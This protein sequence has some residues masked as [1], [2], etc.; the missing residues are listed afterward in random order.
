MRLDSDYILNHHSLDAYFFLRFWKLVALVCGI[1]WPLT[2]VVLMPLYGT[3]HGG[4]KEFDKIS[5]SNIDAAVDGYRLYGVAFVAW[6]VF[7][8]SLMQA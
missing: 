1:G 6:V 7:G 8:K 2:W 4:E 3:A 5:F